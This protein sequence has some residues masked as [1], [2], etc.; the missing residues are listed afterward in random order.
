MEVLIQLKK[1]L[2]NLKNKQNFKQSKLLRRNKAIFKGVS[3]ILLIGILSFGLLPPKK[4]T[5]YL[6]GDS[7]MANKE[8]NTFPETGWGMPFQYYFDTTVTV[9]NRAKNGASTRTFMEEG[10]WISVMQALKA[11]DYVF[12]QFGHNDEVPTKKSYTTPQQFKENLL[13]FVQDAR[14]KNAI[15]ILITPAAR[16]Q[17][18]SAGNVINTHPMYSDLVIEVASA[19]NVPLIN[20]DSMSRAL[21]KQLGPEKSKFLWINLVKGENPHYP[22]GRVDNTHFNELGARKMAELVLQDIEQL[23]LDLVNRIQFR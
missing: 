4:I 10:L 23:H 16:R 6:I 14:S 7:T 13:K 12:I 9:D 1:F 17:F 19:N 20:L 18:D 15:P 22:N 21:L 3:L 11:D 8:T 2:I 5:V